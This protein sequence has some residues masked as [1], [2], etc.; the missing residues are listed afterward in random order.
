MTDLT[1]LLD[2]VLTSC[3]DNWA[4][5]PGKEEITAEWWLAFLGHIPDNPEHLTDVQVLAISIIGLQ[6][7][8]H[9]V[10]E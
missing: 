9:N 10:R 6:E 7:E 2:Q 5:V 3:R 4:A 8:L 1:P